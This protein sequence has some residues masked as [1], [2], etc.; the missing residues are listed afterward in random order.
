[1]SGLPKLTADGR[2][3]ALLR[4]AAFA[5]AQGAAAALAA[6]AVRAVFA[7]LHGAL[8]PPLWALAALPLAG[9]AMAGARVA[10]RAA[11]EG[12]GYDYAAAV[13]RRLLAHLSRQSARSVAR[14]STGALSIRF[15]GDLSAVRNWVARGV[16][17]LIAAAIVAPLALLALGLFDARLAL[18]AAAPM[19]LGA[20]A[21]LLMARGLAPVQRNLRALRARLAAEMT[22]RAPMAPELRLIGRMA[23]ETASL[24]KRARALREAA[25]AHARAAAAVRAVADAVWGL[26]AASLVGVTLLVGAPAAD[27]AMALA[28]SALTLQ[29]LRD[30]AAIADRR[31]AWRVARDRLN[32]VLREPGMFQKAPS[33]APFARR[34][35]LT[36]RFEA[37][38]GPG[39][40]LADACAAPGAKIAL[41][42]PMGGGK[43]ALI[44]LAA[45]LE[46]PTAGAVTLD[47]VAPLALSALKR[48]RA[49][50]YVGPRA[51]IL[52]GSL[53][54][55]L[56]LGVSPRPTENA[57]RAAADRFGLS[58]ALARLG[59]LDGRVEEAGRNLSTGERQGLLLARASLGRPRLMLLD[60]PLA[61]LDAGGRK[62]ALALIAGTSAT[63]LAAGLDTRAAAR[64]DRVWRMEAGTL[65]DDGPPAQR[66]GAAAA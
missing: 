58:A 9:F 47:G 49:I 20:V 39:V 52:R 7:A 19:A 8:T 37:A 21:M 42:G 31:Q 5:V 53:R 4:V 6:V 24:E 38:Q 25:V 18:A 46:A 27:L 23:Q 45:G 34:G 12:L 55:A 54:R 33:D 1:V 2:R 22:E 60:A 35:P 43:S 11:A 16:T 59:G 40:A 51:P 62:A 10:E 14:R 3:R 13:R 17:R 32:A 66:G 50:A 65:S 15:V 29:P 44:A 48:A 64:M 26:S 63:V 56:T 41:T 61:G 57:V 28:L 30:I 36:L